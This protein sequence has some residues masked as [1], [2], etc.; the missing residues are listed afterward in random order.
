MNIAEYNASKG[1]LGFAAIQFRDEDFLKNSQRPSN[2]APWFVCNSFNDSWFRCCDDW[3]PTAGVGL[4]IKSIKVTGRTKIDWGRGD[5]L[6]GQMII[7]KDFS[8]EL[9]KEDIWIYFEEGV[10]V[11]DIVKY[12]EENSVRWVDGLASMWVEE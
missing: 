7:E 2:I 10:D 9:V 1:E 12:V 5:V 3:R 11:N 6:K 4:K 8:D